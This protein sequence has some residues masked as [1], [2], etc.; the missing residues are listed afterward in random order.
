M[1]RR[2]LVVD[3]TPL[4][5]E[6]LRV[7]LELDG[8]EVET[9]YDGRSA[10]TRLRERLFHLVITDLRM[11]DMSGVDLLKAV[12]SERLPFGVIVLTAHGD[13]QVALDA[14]KAG[15][16]D[17]VTKPYEPDHLRFLVKRILERRRLIDELEQLRKQMREDYS[18]HNM[19]SKSPRMRKTF[20]LIEQIGPLG[21][22][23][24]INGETG[25]GKELVA[26]AIHAA[27]SR[28][29]GPFVALNCAALHDALLESELFGHERGSFTGADRRKKGRFELADGGTL[30]LDEVGDVSPAMQAKLLRVLQSGTFE[31]VGGTE[32]L[33]VDVRIVAA[34]NKRLEDEV[35]AGRFRTDLFYRLNVIRIELPPLRERAEDI[36]LLAMHFLE[37]LTPMSNP[38]VTEIDSEAMQALI[39]HTW[40]GNV[41][42]LENAI[43][44]AVA[45][46][47]GSVIHRDALPE[48]VA[49][50]AP[51]PANSSPLIDIE[52][53][54]PDL[55]NDLIGRVERDYFTRLLAC[56]RGNVARCARHSGL[57][58]RSVTQ[59]LQKYDLDRTRFKDTADVD[60]AEA[61]LPMKM[62]DGR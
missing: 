44:A 38:P 22:T 26:Q 24:L 4:I 34:S 21:S 28:H 23:V 33:K 59:K 58:R 62:E 32:T 14:M 15:A 56:Y 35:K 61:G 55:T 5:R 6:H 1:K 27:D 42:E 60:P 8:H 54:L 40:P 47:D 30:F 52:R 13:T 37:K 11:P 10:L 3:D 46:A 19:V 36:P 43:K 41:R 31:R 16:D 2:I 39:E 50:R 25:T 20:D 51:R 17:F 57:S 45:M 18:F 29:T 12:R 48:S 7:I 49:P 53:P 9:A